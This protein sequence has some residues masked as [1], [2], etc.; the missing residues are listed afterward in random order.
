MIAMISQETYVYIIVVTWLALV[1]VY[2]FLIKH[3]YK[4]EDR[5]VEQDKKIEK[6][7]KRMEEQNNQLDKWYEILNKHISQHD[8][9]TNESIFMRYDVCEK[10]RDGYTKSFEAVKLQLEKINDTLEQVKDSVVKLTIQVN[11]RHE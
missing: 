6:Q 7:N 8:I 5:M 4:V 11:K 10:V 3:S 1:G 9:H 2:A